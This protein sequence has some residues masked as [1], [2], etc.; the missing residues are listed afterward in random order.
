MEHQWYV[1]QVFSNYE[2]K[3]MRMLQERIKIVGLEKAIIDIVVPME[4]VVELKGGERKPLKENFSQ[5]MY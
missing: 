2:N 5:G 3:V 4:E 1:L